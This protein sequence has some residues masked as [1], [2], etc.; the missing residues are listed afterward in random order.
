[1]F[2]CCIYRYIHAAVI[3]FHYDFNGTIL[4]PIPAG[5][6]V[7]HDDGDHTEGHKSEAA[8]F[9]GD[10]GNIA[11]SIQNGYFTL[12]GDNQEPML[13][14]INLTVPAGECGTPLCV[15]YE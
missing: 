8:D 2:V 9:S 12:N 3:M 5:G 7:R 13:S 15:F 4:V 6:D 14:D 11:V 1:M 10:A